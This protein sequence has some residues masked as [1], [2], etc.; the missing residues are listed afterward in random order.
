MSFVAMATWSSVPIIPA[1]SHP[2]HFDARDGLLSPVGHCGAAD[3]EACLLLEHFLIAPLRIMP[4]DGVLECRTDRTV[5]L[6]GNA[7]EAHRRLAL[8]APLVVNRNRLCHKSRIAERAAGAR[9][10]F[11]L[12][13]QHLAV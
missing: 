7:L 9:M 4:L 11:A 6:V 1:S 2:H 5:H 12:L 8:H 3:G 10:T 13:D